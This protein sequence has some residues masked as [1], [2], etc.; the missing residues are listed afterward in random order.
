M[1]SLLREVNGE[2]LVLFLDEI[3]VH[4]RTL[5]EHKVHLRRLFEILRP[6]KLVAKRSKCNTG[7]VE[8]ELLGFVIDRSGAVRNR[9]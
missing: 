6:N 4:S 7:D 3:L 1:S 9:G 5:E 8:V 2:C